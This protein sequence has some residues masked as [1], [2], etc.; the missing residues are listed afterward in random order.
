M[1]NVALWGKLYFSPELDEIE[2]DYTFG[3]INIWMECNLV[4]SFNMYETSSRR[5]IYV[6]EENSLIKFDSYGHFDDS[7]KQVTERTMVVYDYKKMKKTTFKMVPVKQKE[8]GLEDV[9]FAPL[10]KAVFNKTFIFDETQKAPSGCDE[11]SFKITM[12]E[13][14][15]YDEESVKAY[16]RDWVNENENKYWVYKVV[17]NWY[18]DHIDAIAYCSIYEEQDS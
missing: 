2:G 16:I 11:V 8:M 9:E 6:Q 7:H 5:T 10:D 14:Y 4:D 12:S 13:A 18:R 15:L 3:D 1:M 17:A